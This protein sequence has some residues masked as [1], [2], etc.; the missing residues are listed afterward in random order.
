MRTVI[1]PYCHRPAEF[2]DSAEVYHGRSYGMIYLCRPCD[3][4]VGCHKAGSGDE[5]LGRLAN[6]ELRNWKVQ[7]HNAFDPLWKDQMFFVRRTD[8]YAWLA[9]Q[10][11]LPTDKTHIGLFDVDQCKQVVQIC[12][13]FRNG[14]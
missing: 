5:P 13:D 4:F 2:L 10:L 6:A 1:C 3:A 9:K 11:H 14:F 7:A 12:E 8:A